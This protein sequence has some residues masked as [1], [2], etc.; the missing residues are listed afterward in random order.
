MALTARQVEQA[1]NIL[2]SVLLTK[3]LRDMIDVAYIVHT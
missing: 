1:E 2:S 3:N